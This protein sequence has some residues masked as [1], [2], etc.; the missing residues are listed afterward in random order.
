MSNKAL[1]AWSLIASV[2]V[3]GGLFIFPPPYDRIAN[4]IGIMA[5]LARAILRLRQIVN[6]AK[7]SPQNTK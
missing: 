4:W 7:D 3:L 5:L 2:L 6:P 1:I